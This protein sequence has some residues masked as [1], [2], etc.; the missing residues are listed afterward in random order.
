MNALNALN[1]SLAIPEIFVLSMA[2]TVLMADVFFGKTHQKLAYSLSLLTLAIA[3]FLSVQFSSETAQIAFNGLFISDPLSTILKIFIYMISFVV[4]IYSRQYLVDRNLFKGEY[5]VLIL[6]AVLGM[7]IM[8]SAANFLPMYLGLELL[9]LSMYAM[10]AMYR[11]SKQASEAA[12]KF[13]VL[14]AIASGM[15]LYGMSMIYGATGSLDH[16]VINN[17][18]ANY[19]DDKILLIFGLVFIVAGIAFKLGVAPFHMWAP[20]VYQ[21][22]PTAVTMFIGTVPK[23]AGFI[24]AYRLLVDALMGLGADWQQMLIILSILSIG[25]GNVVAVA[26]TNIKRMLAYSAIAHMGYMMLGLLA[27]TQSGFAASLFYTLVYTIMTAGA[28]GV[29][30]LIS[31]SGQEADQLQDIKGLGKRCPWLAL[32]MLILMFSMAGVPPFGGF[33]S[34]WFVLKEIVAVGHLWLAVAAV[35][36]A[37]IGVF[38]YLRIVRLMYFD[39]AEEIEIIAPTDHKLFL[40]LNGLVVLMLGLMPGIL[41]TVCLAVFN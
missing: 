26:Q 5:F 15:L 20:D 30:T 9:S 36:F 17:A 29:I 40:G 21:G 24:L 39:S 8:A 7:M 38:F 3:V 37:I 11:D 2:C 22:A 1:Y 23:L 4:L 35:F 12:M 31:Q 19:Q 34:K 6:F 18:I 41:L 32:I 14:G 13:F 16:S 25:L 33:W 28:F 27:G 10:V